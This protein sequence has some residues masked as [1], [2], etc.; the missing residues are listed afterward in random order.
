MRKMNMYFF[1]EEEIHPSDAGWFYGILGGSI[2][3]TLFVWV[4]TL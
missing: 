4:V 2:L 3:L 1:G